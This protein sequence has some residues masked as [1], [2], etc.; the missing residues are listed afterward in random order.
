MSLAEEEPILSS[1]PGDAE[2]LENPGQRSL[3]GDIGDLFEDGRTYIEAE[4]AFQKTRGAYAAGQAK[5][6]LIYA[7]I[8]IGLVFFAM[9]GITVGLII[10]LAPI[11]TIWGST[12]LVSGVM[13]IGAA[14]A[15]SKV[16]GHARALSRAFK[17]KTG[18]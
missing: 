7:V 16:I 11:I 6:A 14:I 9:L 13:L 1:R 3:L 17:N 15:L 10:A 8:A 18:G 2:E 12:A 5:S 4:L